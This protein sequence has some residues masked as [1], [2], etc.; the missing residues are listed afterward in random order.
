LIFSSHHTHSHTN[1]NVLTFHAYLVNAAKL[2]QAQGATVII[3]SATPN[4]VWEGGKYAWAPNRF[5]TF[6]RDAAAAAGATFV[7][8]GYYTAAL[9]EKLGSAVVNS[10]YPKDHTHTAPEGAK[11]V[12]RAFITALEATGS[13]LKRY[14]KPL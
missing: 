13:T 2:F 4:N 9:Y 1:E 5:T 10:Y 11:T 8:H 12:A 7:D 3:S 14:V 6:S